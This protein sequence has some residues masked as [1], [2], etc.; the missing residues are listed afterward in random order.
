[1][2]KQEKG[3]PY[4][5]LLV[6]AVVV[7]L[8]AVYL[9]APKQAPRET[10]GEIINQS[11][12]EEK[13]ITHFAEPKVYSPYYE[14]LEALIQAELN[15]T[16]KNATR[17]NYLPAAMFAELP[18][19]PSDLYQM[20]VLF[21]YYQMGK[22]RNKTDLENKELG[23]EYWKQPE[24]IPTF[25]TSGL[26]L[27]QNPPM[28]TRYYHWAEYELIN[29]NQLRNKNTG[30]VITLTPGS[31][32]SVLPNKTIEVKTPRVGIEGY[33]VYPS[34]MVIVDAQPD[35]Y[36]DVYTVLYCGWYVQMYQGVKLEAAFPESGSIENFQ[37]FEDGTKVVTQNPAEVEKYFKVEFEP[38]Q[39]VLEPSFPIFKE[40]WAKLI[41]MRITV[42]ESTPKGKYIVGMNIVAPSKEFNE[43]MMWKYKT[44]YRV[45][46]VG[47]GRPF[48][49]VFIQVV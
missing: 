37:L 1:M 11:G 47:I 27:I 45:G 26:P 38:E 48:F 15:K 6:V 34:D 8:A 5:Y 31:V 32:A 21:K 14:G 25:F 23:P 4:W 22:I 46:E 33:T 24:W 29:A 7:I 13:N 20:Q 36:F 2:K 9:L 39:F 12:G 19:F 30:Q 17:G 3:N 28:D 35:T 43:D 49:R 42:N 18:A 41:R 40:E 44:Q 16:S 10:G